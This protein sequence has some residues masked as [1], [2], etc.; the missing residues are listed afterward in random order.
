MPTDIKKEFEAVRNLFPHTNDVVYFNSASYGPFSKP[1][2]DAVNENMKIRMD[3]YNDDSHDAFVL[4]VNLRERYAKLIG[5][6][7]EEVGVGLSTTMGINIAAFGLPLE[8][9]DEILLSHKE[10]PALVYTFQAAADERG[11]KIKMIDTKDDHVDIDAFAKAIT[12]KT[13]VIAVSFVQFFNGYKNDLEALSALCQK[14]N[15]YFVVDGIQGLGAEQIDVSKLKI[16]IFSSGCQKW[17]LSPQGCAIF[18]LSNRI[19]NKLRIP[20]MSW[21]GVD[22]NTQFG[23]L[24]QYDKPYFETAEKFELGYYA[25][26]NLYGMA[27][28]LDIFERLSIEKIQIHNHA[29]IDML[30]EYI[31]KSPHFEIT[32]T[33]D[34]KYRSSIFTFKTEKNEELKQFL[35][36][37]K[38]IVVLREG[39]IRV[40]VHLY[41]D[42]SD[43]QKLIDALEEFI[44][45]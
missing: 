1:L 30:A 42:E 29:L 32:S 18:Y 4:R 3:A 38:I 37:R 7:T 8:E 39:S 14:H 43:I 26:L 44:N 2:V 35:F 17:M 5:A 34:K 21:L 19:R 13:K 41:N 15:L 10:F 28:S 9:G 20:F 40:S 12:R 33:L 11:Y 36:D 6:Q 27:A 16:D 22:W 31:Q 23:D 25:V 45:I 24:F